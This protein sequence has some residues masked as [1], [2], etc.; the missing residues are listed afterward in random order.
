MRICMTWRA[1]AYCHVC[2]KTK[3]KE[4]ITGVRLQLGGPAVEIGKMLQDEDASG[5][6]TQRSADG[7]Q[8]SS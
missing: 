4:A 8:I 6:V 5:W 3:Q 7:M 2:E 1:P